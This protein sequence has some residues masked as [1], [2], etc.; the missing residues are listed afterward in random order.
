VQFASKLAQVLYQVFLDNTMNFVIGKD[1]R[2][3]T[4]ELERTFAQV[5]KSLGVNVFLLGT[6]ST[7]AVSF[8][9]RAYKATCGIMITGSSKPK[10]FVGFKIFNGNGLKISDEQLS[11][12]EFKFKN[13]STI[14]L[15]QK[16]GKVYY[17]PYFNFEYIN[18]L[19]QFSLIDKKANSIK[20]LADLSCGSGE[21]LYEEFCMALGLKPFIAHGSFDCDKINQTFTR[22]VLSSKTSNFKTQDSFGQRK[23]NKNFF[24]FK[25]VFDGDCDKIVFF[26]SNGNKIAN[27]KLLLLFALNEKQQGKKPY[28][29][30]G[31]MTNSKLFE[32]LKQENIEFGIM[33]DSLTQKKLIHT[34]LETGADICGDNFGNI[35]FMNNALTSD[36]FL[37]L[38]KFLNIFTQN[39]DLVLKVI[40]MP[41][42][43]RFEK[44]IKIYHKF[45]MKKF[46]EVINLC[47]FSLI[48]KGKIF[49]R[50]N[51][52]LNEIEIILETEDESLKEEIF[53]FLESFIK[54][55]KLN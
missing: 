30:L 22:S 5:F 32:K 46:E 41:L 50:Q 19:K 24:D 45:D 49:I 9:T 47:E 7:A 15:K 20:I 25:I 35:V 54:K 37:T 13:L 52:F 18:F 40:E 12:I 43:K 38:I 2:E 16:E 27:E 4:G 10:D 1:T 17:K 29:I 33:Q 23:N 26:D 34:A 44:K 28:L 42:A 55:E 8:A 53:S 36:A 48:D 31:P 39:R 3:N 6:T 21:E 11:A 51:K 14:N